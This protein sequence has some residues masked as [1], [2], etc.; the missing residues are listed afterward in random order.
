M[1][2]VELNFQPP[3]Y[4]KQNKGYK[5]LR[6]A[7]SQE[8]VEIVKSVQATPGVPGPTVRASTAP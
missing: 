8:L 3:Y 1:V 2:S 6:E 7:V 4:E 5:Q